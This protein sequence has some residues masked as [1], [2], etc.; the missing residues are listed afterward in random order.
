MPDVKISAL[1][2]STTPLAGTEVLPIVQSATTRQVS[3]ANLTAGRAVNALSITASSLTNGRVTYAG[4]SGLLTDSANLLYSGTDLTVY[5]LTV[6]RGLGAVATNTAIGASALPV[7]TTGSQNTATGY[8]ALNVNTT[9]ATNAAFG[10]GT[11]QN[12]TTASGNT[13]I[14]S[15]AQLFTTTGA[16]NVSVGRIAL[17]FNT[18]G[19]SNVA[20]GKEALFSNTTAS[21]NTAIGYVALYSNT[22]G[23]PNTAV[24]AGALYSNTT[25]ASNTGLGVDAG[26]SNSTGS[27]NTA[28]GRQALNSNTTA[29]NNTAVGYQAAYSNTTAGF[30]TAL[31]YQ[32]GYSA[33]SGYSL[34]VGNQAGYNTTGAGNTFVGV[35][36]SSGFGAGY[37]VTTGGANTILGGYSG[38]QGGLDIRTASNYIVLSDGSGNPNLIIDNNKAMLL[39]HVTATSTP[40]G[41]F[42]FLYNSGEST[43]TTGHVTGTLT[44]TPYALFNYNGTTIGSITQSGT[45]AVLY[46]VTSDQRLKINIVDAPSGNIDDIK[47]RSF[48]WVTDGTHQE[49]GM[50]A[51]ELLEVAP[52]AVYQPQNS[53]E[54]MAVDYSKL[55]PMMI[56]EIQDLK[57]R[58]TALENK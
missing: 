5:G 23:T 16:E 58:L 11:L 53:D 41:G 57:A 27:F 43:M 19:A 25:G 20:V 48:D 4:A 31:G 21:N 28:V 56:K 15:G 37:A 32:A 55:V 39:G 26:Y 1:P 44:G 49:Y 12:A 42:G 52:Y 2:A 34:Y 45:T 30:I 40:L 38:N 35:N 6:G 22:T 33:T 54:M 9:G 29:S 51:Q 17:F 50:V 24:G 18:T 10:D 7:N 46:N 3:V 36:S 8:Q 47:I 14:G 13:A